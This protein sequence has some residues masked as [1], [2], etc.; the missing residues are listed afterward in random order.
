MSEWA[1]FTGKD[2][3]GIKAAAALRAANR[4]SYFCN[5]EFRGYPDS[6]G[7]ETH[8]TLCGIC[9][10]MERLGLYNLTPAPCHLGYTMSEV[11]G[12]SRFVRQYTLASGGSYCDCGY[13]KL[14]T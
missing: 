9:A 5:L 2:I 6:R 10:L 14:D 13:K 7:Y 11:G 8:F 3:R 12:V 1:K 4:N